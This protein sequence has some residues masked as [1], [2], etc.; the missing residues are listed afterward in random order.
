MLCS[1]ADEGLRRVH[2][3]DF[4]ERLETIRCRICQQPID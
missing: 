1:N 2:H 4:V 3:L